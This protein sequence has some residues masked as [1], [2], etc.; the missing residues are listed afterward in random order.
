MHD[1]DIGHS[2]LVSRTKLNALRRLVEK[3]A[4]MCH[5]L[6]KRYGELADKAEAQQEASNKRFWDGVISTMQDTTKMVDEIFDAVQALTTDNED[7]NEKEG[8]PEDAPLKNHQPHY[9]TSA[10]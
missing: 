1:L 5:E 3:Q 4:Y 7:S 8:A 6:V 10:S 9:T 2:V